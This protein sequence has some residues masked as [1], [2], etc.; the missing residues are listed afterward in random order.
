MKF[1]DLDFIV[2]MAIEILWKDITLRG[3]LNCVITVK[4]KINSFFYYP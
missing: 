3:S 4:D 2:N 1:P